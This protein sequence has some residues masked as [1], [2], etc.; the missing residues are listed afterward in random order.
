MRYNIKKIRKKLEENEKVSLSDVTVDDVDDIDS[1]V[2]DKKKSSNDRILSFLNTVK[3]P[4]IFKVDNKL[5]KISFSDNSN[6]T[7]DECLTNVL[8]NLFK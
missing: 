5:V 6:K 2:I 8:K 4:Y 3:N 1:I 7:A